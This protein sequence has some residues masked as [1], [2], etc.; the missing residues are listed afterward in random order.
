MVEAGGEFVDWIHLLRHSTVHSLSVPNCAFRSRTIL[1]VATRSVDEVIDVLK[2]SPVVA[3]HVK[4]KVV[5]VIPF[6]VCV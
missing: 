6:R 2:I 5:I 1:I 3:T 4:L